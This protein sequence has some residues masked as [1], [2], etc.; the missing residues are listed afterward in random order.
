MWHD[1][2]LPSDWA[3]GELRIPRQSFLLTPAKSGKA[4]RKELEVSKA[5]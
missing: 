2:L 1:C 5:V 3:L 4:L